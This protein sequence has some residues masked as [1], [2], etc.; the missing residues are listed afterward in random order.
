MKNTLLL[1]LCFTGFGAWSQ[2]TV[3]DT[4]FYTGSEQTWTVP[5]G[6]SNVIID[7]YGAKGADG[8][9]VNPGVNSGGAA[10]LGN[11][12]TGNWSSLNPNDVLYVYVG[13]SANGGNGGYNGGGNGVANP[14]ANP[15]GGG[16]GA[17]DIRF[18]GN[19]LSDRIQV[20]GGGGGGGNAAL[21]ATAGTVSG[22]NGGNGGGNQ[23]LTGNSLDGQAGS[24]CIG[25]ETNA[26][27]Y[28]YFGAGG[29][30]T[31][32][33]GAAGNG[34]PSFL[35]SAGS[36]ANGATGG[37]GGQG[38]N[39][40]GNTSTLMAPSG[41]GGGGG[42]TG[43]NG[44][45]GG[46]LGTD[47]CGGN[48]SGA[49]GGGS[50][51]TN[52]FDGTPTDFANG[53][54]DGDGYV[55]ISYT[56]TI[57]TA[58]IDGSFQVPCVD[59]TVLIWGTPGNGMWNVITGPSGDMFDGEFSP[60]METTYVMTY[61][62]SSCGV[63]T[64]DT[65]SVG[66]DCTLGLEGNQAQT[67]TVYPNPATSLLTLENGL[68]ASVRILDLTGHEVLFIE[69]NQQET[70]TIAPLNPGI[71]LLEVQKDNSIQQVRFVKE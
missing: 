3:K 56:L 22:G 27:T 1:G 24:T 55:V 71:Y 29:G 48:A 59:D 34:C 68:N 43:G 25:T 49:G 51:G 57:D 60:S 5:C 30:T 33:T 53:V 35:G 50:A 65:I 13:G 23:T 54:N 36:P 41:G 7:A 42:Y 15:S 14:A 28:T 58:Q 45:G 32:G 39:L 9:T 61:T 21:H 19:A 4:L 20:A 37:N 70:I 66:I 46:S 62:T 64:T 26:T 69:K 38:N 11:R 47:A 67:V 2:V 31:T 17:T 10:G 8:K 6:A 63:I 44:G 52:Y 16:G 12:V 18:P 40:F